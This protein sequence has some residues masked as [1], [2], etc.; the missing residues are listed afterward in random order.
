MASR[1]QKSV[2]ALLGQHRDAVDALRAALGDAADA[3]AHDDLWLL[4]FVLSAKGDAKRAQNA[5]LETIRYRADNAATLALAAAGSPH[6]LADSLG[7][8]LR[9]IS[10][11]T[12]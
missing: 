3:T 11:A 8:L 7:G 2:D 12:L 5:A 4:R 6:P 10:T 1:E 9:Q